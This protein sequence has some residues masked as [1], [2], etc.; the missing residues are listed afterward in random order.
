MTGTSFFDTNVLLYMYNEA[1]R[2]KQIRARALFEEHAGNGKLVLST[3]VVQEFYSVGT[4]K[5]GL[6]R[7]LLRTAVD[8]LLTFPTVSVIPRHIVSAIEIEE[9]YRVS[10]WDALILATAASCGASVLYTED[11]S[12]GQKYDSVVVRNPFR[13]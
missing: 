12:D 4:R 5:L 8:L 10:F 2:G 1:D 13:S 7:P 3:Q 9:R 11:L 6:P